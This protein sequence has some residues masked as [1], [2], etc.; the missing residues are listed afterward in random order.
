MQDA[1]E[2]KIV[3]V[4]DDEHIVPLL[5]HYISKA[6]PESKITRYKTVDDAISD[7]QEFEDFDLVIT[8][9]N[10]PGKSTGADLVR[11]VL[12]KFNG[13]KTDSKQKAII[14]TSADYNNSGTI[15]EVVTKAGAWMNVLFLRKPEEITGG[16]LTEQ[17]R[18]YSPQKKRKADTHQ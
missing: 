8:D 17:V 12:T 3:L 11:Y 2:H 15:D 18:H 13:Y 9:F 4:E 16:Q 1:Q 14:V 10:T 5:I 6:A 7:I